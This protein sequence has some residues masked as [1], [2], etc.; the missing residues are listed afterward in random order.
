M[1]LAELNEKGC[2]ELL[3]IGYTGTGHIS[4]RKLK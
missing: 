3:L 4:R 1:Q 2:I